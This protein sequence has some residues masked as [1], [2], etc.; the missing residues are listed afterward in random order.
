MPYSV[1]SLAQKNRAKTL[2]RLLS[3][4]RNLLYRDNHWGEGSK[5]NTTMNTPLFLGLDIG[6][7][8][9]RAVLFDSTGKRHGTGTAPLVT[10][11]PQPGWAE[12]QP[13]DWWK[14]LGQAVPEAL[15]QAGCGAEAVAAIG[16]DS[17]AC[18]VL[19]VDALGMPI[20]PALLWMDQRSH[21]EA[22]LLT[23]TEDPSLRWVSNHV[24]PE[25]MLP[26]ALW[27][28]QS[29]PASYQMA[30]RLVE[31]TDWIMYQLTGTWTLSLNHVA[32]K[33]NYVAPEGGWSRSLLEKVG[34]EDLPDKWPHDVVPYGGGT[35]KLSASAAEAL[36][37][38]AGTPV[39]QGGIDAYAGMIGLGA[40]APGK[41]A[42]IM[43]SS[44][45]HL[46]NADQPFL[47]TGMSGCYADAIRPGL[48]TLEGGQTATGSIVN[49][50]R[51]HFAGN[52]EKEAGRVGKS[53]YELLDDKAAKVSPGC[54][55]LLCLDHW[56]GAR[57][58][59]KDPLSRGTWWG[60]TLSHGPGHLLRSIYEGTA[61][62]TRAILE[63]LARHG[64]PVTQL[65]AG[66]GGV[67]SR[68]WLQIHADV[69]QAPLSIPAET[70]ACALGSAMVAAVHA[71]H[72]VSLEEAAASMVRLEAVIEPNQQLSGMYAEG[73]ERY[74]KLYEALG[75]IH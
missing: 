56:Q 69:C 46:V 7:Q 74:R 30:H 1:T 20:R 16:L 9:V 47:G 36:G 51:E 4:H 64:L 33:W 24:S 26:K 52:E 15:R 12:Q 75:A 68:L 42:M 70:E 17:T 72:F 66:G 65:I 32:V 21:S 19:A 44:T 57:T 23:L 3:G 58:P 71:G 29:E 37:L 59:L 43:G 61:Y 8:S 49:W 45:C 41:L 5:Y 27:L 35:G 22:Q 18:T 54:D 73:Y 60:L 10:T 2:Y 48:Y 34:L 63:D 13:L 50:Y 11:Y 14:G 6:T 28:K 25:W 55:G 38:N 40:I 62:G 67:K 39:A 31:C 53:V